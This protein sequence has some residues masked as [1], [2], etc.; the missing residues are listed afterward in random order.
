MHRFKRPCYLLG[1]RLELIE[2]TEQGRGA[3]WWG[4][5]PPQVAAVHPLPPEPTEN[6]NST[7]VSNVS[8]NTLHVDLAWHDFFTTD[9]ILT[10]QPRALLRSAMVAL[11]YI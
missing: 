9:D 4:S 6:H 1:C 11:P 2:G 7:Q 5:V 8:S 10:L 3:G